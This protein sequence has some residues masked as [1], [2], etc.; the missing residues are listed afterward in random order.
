MTCSSSLGANDFLL[1]FDRSRLCRADGGIFHSAAR[2]DV[3][4]ACLHHASSGFLRGHGLTAAA[5]CAWALGSS[6]YYERHL[7]LGSVARPISNAF[8]P[9]WLH[10]FLT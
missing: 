5:F 8:V 10:F 6:L 4:R 7:H 2:L 1:C 9:A 3:E